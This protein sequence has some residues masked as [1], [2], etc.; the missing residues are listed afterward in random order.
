MLDAP[1]NGHVQEGVPLV[2]ENVCEES[3]TL[4]INMEYE[5]PFLVK[6]IS[7]SVLFVNTLVELNHQITWSENE[8]THVLSMR[9]THHSADVESQ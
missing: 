2:I 5:V 3:K 9:I 8:T 7:Y 1:I 4:S 6:H